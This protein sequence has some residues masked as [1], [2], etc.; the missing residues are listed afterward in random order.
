MLRSPDAGATWTLVCAGDLDPVE[1]GQEPTVTSPQPEEDNPLCS[2]QV[3]DVVALSVVAK[4]ILPAGV[5][6][7]PYEGTGSP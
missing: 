4:A 3:C 2:G 7:T 1:M 6:A 5:E